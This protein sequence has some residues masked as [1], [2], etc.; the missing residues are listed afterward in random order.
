MIFTVKHNVDTFC[1]VP[2]NNNLS[3]QYHC[4]VLHRWLWCEGL[5]D[6]DKKGRNCMKEWSVQDLTQAACDHNHQSPWSI[7]GWHAALTFTY[8]ICH[9]FTINHRFM[10][11]V[12]ARALKIFSPS[13]L[14]HPV[15]LSLTPFFHPPPLHPFIAHT[16]SLL[17]A[18]CL[19]VKKVKVVNGMVIDN[20]N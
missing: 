15:L 9:H 5:K 18:W 12:N 20:V 7:V 14:C 3:S 6:K 13:S 4:G 16:L 19:T 17:L 11:L 2:I 8:I 10:T 1:L